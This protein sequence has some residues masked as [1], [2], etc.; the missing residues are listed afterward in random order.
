[1]KK[2]YFVL[3]AVL[4]FGAI[5][6][7][8]TNPYRGEASFVTFSCE[9][10][11]S[12]R[13]D[14]G[15]FT[16]PIRVIGQH[17]SFSVTVSG[18]DGTA[19]NNTHYT[20]LEPA[21]GVLTFEATD[22]LK[23][24][25]FGVNRIP[26]Y[27][28]PGSV[29]FKVNIDNATSGIERGSRS[30]VN[31]TITDADHPLADLIGAWTVT[32]WDATNSTG[33]MAKKTYTMNLSAYD[34]DITRLWCDGINYMPKDATIAS[35]VSMYPVYGI[36]SEDH[37][38]ISFPTEQE[39]GNLGSNNGGML[40]LT[41]GYTN[42]G[43]YVKN[44]DAIVFTRQE[45]GSYRCDDGILWLNSYVWPTYGGYFLGSENGVFTTWVKQ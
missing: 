15:S 34:G 5:S 23:Y 40:K 39:G 21:S 26:G 12:L 6:C 27:V 37:A 33:G 20:I 36:V 2:I 29:E 11:Y 18:E 24:V 44:I 45:D 3:A 42:N 35:V 31:V 25:R 19:K 9:T 8:R 32:G 41:S 30:T 43:Y 17:G 13:E 22:S 16:L 28:E 38:T 1:M 4:A 10:S 7:D 14:A